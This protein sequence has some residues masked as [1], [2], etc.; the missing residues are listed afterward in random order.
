[1]VKYNIHWEELCNVEIEAENEDEAREFWVN[2]DY[3]NTNVDRYL[4]DDP[5]ITKI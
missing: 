4:V 5:I 2:Q 3:D 1:M